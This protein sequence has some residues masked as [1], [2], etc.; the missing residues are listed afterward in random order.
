MSSPARILGVFTAPT[1][2]F[3]SIA[4]APH[5]ILCW[6]LQIVLGG[7]YFWYLLHRLGAVELARQS[8]EQS[9]RARAMDP[10]TLQT[11]INATAHFFV[12][13]P[14][15]TAGMVIVATLLLAAIFLGVANLL[16]GMEA[17][18]KGVLAVVVHA[19]LPQTLLAVL[20][21]LVLALMN[22]PLAFHYVNPLGSNFGFF[23]NK[24]TTPAFVYT[25]ATHSDLFVLWTV[26][27]LA[28]GLAKLS[29]RPRKFASSFWAVFALWMFYIIVA[30]GVAAVFA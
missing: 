14:Y 7:A 12:Y 18:F 8:L 9:A 13:M 20:S 1:A 21:A 23:L 17:R 24:A 29:G 28:L 10:A 25:F 2:T 16:L 6:V 3:E 4:E 27:L 15:I 22:D 5:F 19:M 11:S 30:S 26:V